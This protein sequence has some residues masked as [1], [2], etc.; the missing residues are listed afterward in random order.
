M[1]IEQLNASQDLG[2]TIKH[3]KRIVIE[4]A[5]R[6]E[7]LER[8]VFQ[9]AKEAGKSVDLKAEHAVVGTVKSIEEKM[10]A[11]LNG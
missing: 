10:K 9:G 3:L 2:E 4:Q 6:I 8:T 5:K 7:S 11:L 1:S